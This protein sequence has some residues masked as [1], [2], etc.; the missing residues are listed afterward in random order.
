M[1]LPKRI[2]GRTGLEVTQLG[3]GAMEIRG[4]RIW[5]GRPCS[6]EEADVILNAV[7]D[8]GINFIDTANDYGKSELFIGRH[9]ADRRDLFYLATKC[10]CSMTFAGD[11]DDTPHFYTRDN[12]FRNIADSLMKMEVPCVDLLQLHNPSVQ[13]C[14]E[15]KLVDALRELQSTGVVKFIGCSTTL[16]DIKNYID[17]RVFDVFQ[18]PYSALDRRHED[19]ITRVKQGCAYCHQ[20]GNKATREIQN[21]NQYDST[22]AA[23]DRRVQ[24]S[25]RG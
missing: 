21:L 19:W 14:E 23:W 12:L 18:V 11:H 10:G 15:G 24:S 7:V 8:A 5:N 25:Q 17:W 16:P 1:S 3:Y 4:E 13:Q 2:L 9:L 22:V 20:L 6:S